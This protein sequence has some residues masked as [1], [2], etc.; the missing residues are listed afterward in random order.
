[1]IL[2]YRNALTLSWFYYVIM[3][4]QYYNAITIPYYNIKTCIFI[5]V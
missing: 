2:Q 1:M 3:I 5:I 4:V